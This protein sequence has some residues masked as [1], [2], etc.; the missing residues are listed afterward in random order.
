MRSESLTSPSSARAQAAPAK[1]TL[2]ANQP[3]VVLPLDPALGLSPQRRDELNQRAQRLIDKYSD[4]TVMITANSES[5]GGAHR[6]LLNGARSLPELDY[7]DI[8]HILNDIAADTAL[9]EPDKAYLWTRIADGKLTPDLGLQRPHALYVTSNQG[10]RP[11]VI[12]TNRPADSPNHAFVGFDD[13]YHGRLAM[14]PSLSDSLAGIREHEENEG[15]VPGRLARSTPFWHFNE[16][17]VNASTRTV[18]ALRAYR[19]GGFAAFA[20]AWNRGFV[21]R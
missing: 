8:G 11:E 19:T 13:R 3:A 2:L 4:R 16:G 5:V 21:E 9:S 1:D 7:H 20:A 15:G 10:A 18:E 17:D 14:R 6:Q 12:D